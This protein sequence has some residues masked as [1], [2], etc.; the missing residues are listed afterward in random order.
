MGIKFEYINYDE[1][2]YDYIEKKEEFLSED[3]LFIF[4]DNRMKEIFTRKI[5]GNLFS[6]NPTF[7]TI[8]EFKERV[9]ITDKVILKEAKRILAFF[10]SLPENIKKELE[11]NNYFD[12]IDFANNFFSYYRE[13]NLSCNEGVI[14]YYKWQENYVKYFTEIKQ[15]FDRFAK[16]NNY[17][18]SDWIEQLKYFNNQWL[19]MYSN[20]IFV[21]IVEFPEIY[22]KVIAEIRKT[23]EVILF[24]QMRKKDFDE[25]ELK[26][27]NLSVPLLKKNVRVYRFNDELQEAISLIKLQEKN[28][29]NIYSPAVE[30]NSFYQLFPNNFAPSRRDVMNDTKIF[31]F[32]NIQLQILGA[33]E[34]R[35]KETYSLK[36]MVSAFEDR[37]FA[38]YYD[39]T[40]EDFIKLNNLLKKGYKYMSKDILTREFPED[41]W[42]FIAVVEHIIYDLN[43]IS[44]IRS[45]DKLYEYFQEV[46]DMKKFFETEKDYD[47]KDI[48]E[49]I[50]EI[51]GM[52]KVNESIGIYKDNREIFGNRPG[53][54]LYR[55]L[56]QYM[57]DIVIRS[58]VKV[59]PGIPL[60][61]PLDFIKYAVTPCESLNCFIDIT[62]EYIPK[63]IKDKLIFTEN[64]R[65]DL[66]MITMDEKREIE[67]YRFFQAI[68]SS[69]DSV[70]FTKIDEE[71]GVG[72]TPFLE[73][74]INANEIILEEID[75]SLDSV[76][77]I[78]KNIFS[79]ESIKCVKDECETEEDIQKRPEDFKDG[80]INL[81]A[82]DI[83][84][85]N[86]CPLRFYFSKLRELEP[87]EK[88]EDKDL[89]PRILGI[90][91]HR[92]LE[93][94]VKEM[95]KEVIN[96]KIEVDIDNIKT[97]LEEEFERARYMIQ[98]HMD[99]YIEQ[100]L[101]PLLAR[102]ICRFFEIIKKKYKKRNI[103]R[104]QGEKSKFEETPYYSGKIDVNLIGRADLV[105]ESD[106]G[107][108]IIDYKTGNGGAQQ[109]DYY[110]IILYDGDPY[111]ERVIFNV[112]KCEY[113]EFDKVKL[114]KED[115]DRIVKELSDSEIYSK[116]EKE[117]TCKKC[118]YSRLCRRG[119]NE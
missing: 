49:K 29:I 115:V 112:W 79:G 66:K 108:T 41:E 24:L 90:I 100:I 39:I 26:I 84:I 40:K 85:L 111:T 57:K 93:K 44:T 7:I 14:E 23:H 55:L 17:I 83:D 4:V 98:I 37:T 103:T 92:V 11:I 73:E 94:S 119:E 117:S 34:E 54:G 64:Q 15:S 75:V 22:K 6:N 114:K 25:N 53:E 88:G 97:K 18:P 13:L 9:F 89:D 60:I 76:N 59:S 102:N 87:I 72:M 116:C 20:I 27:K 106:E 48:I 99:N 16:E 46:L 107:N 2:I 51:F 62:D 56:L 21:D 80:K 82:Y 65:K 5:G 19:K 28:K 91:V 31:K 77:T 86:E 96:G 38:E 74:L 70:I 8:D 67:R 101:I 33:K 52:M 50:L 118:I 78:L 43:E 68:C 10:K 47:S 1:K 63:L 30:E 42:R 95:W 105:I 81:G 104:F 71:A 35:L 110:N 69:G 109:L 113:Q 3:N 45:V 36:D 32:L 12:I 61:K 58:T